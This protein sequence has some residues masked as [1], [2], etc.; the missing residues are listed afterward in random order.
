MKQWT[1]TFSS[2]SKANPYSGYPSSLR[3]TTLYIAYLYVY[4]FGSLDLALAQGAKIATA[5]SLSSDDTIADGISSRSTLT[6]NTTSDNLIGSNNMIESL[7]TCPFSQ[8]QGE[9]RY[10]YNCRWCSFRKEACCE[11]E[12]ERNMLKSVNISATDDW[13]C[14]IT[15]VHFQQCG[16]CSPDVKKYLMQTNLSNFFDY[17]WEPNSLAIRPC[18]QACRYIYKQCNRAL[19]LNGSSALPRDV[20]EEEFCAPFP[21]TSSSELPCFNGS[22]GRGWDMLVVIVVS[23]V[24]IMI[25]GVV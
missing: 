18:K 5:T 21:E 13:D 1:S 11:V 17:V 24:T 22:V 10:C 8:W 2:R 14:Y 19:L 7:P 25:V 16:R 3:I 20:S 23:F 15:I 6:R 4:I 12:D 9:P